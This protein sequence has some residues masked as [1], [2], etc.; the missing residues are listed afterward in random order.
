MIVSFNKRTGKIVNMYQCL[1][2]FTDGVMDIPETVTF[3]KLS[4]LATSNYINTLNNDGLQLYNYGDSKTSMISEYS[5]VNKGNIISGIP[6]SVYSG[7]N[8]SPVSLLEV[9]DTPEIISTPYIFPEDYSMFNIDDVVSQYY[10]NLL[11]SSTSTY[12]IGTDFNDLDD[13]NVSLSTYKVL[14][15]RNVILGP[16]DVLILNT[17]KPTVSTGVNYFKL[18]Y[19]NNNDL[20]VYVNSNLLDD[21][22]L[23]NSP[24]SSI[25]ISIKN[26]TERNILL[27]SLAIGYSFEQGGNI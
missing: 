24:I 15:L 13:I 5:N 3:T 1:D 12:L 14:E 17:V 7:V 23:Y 4:E 25:N 20:E 16:D 27:N 18:L 21:S 19:I 11:D 6:F 10:M 8:P 22:Y 9:V 26:P 2:N